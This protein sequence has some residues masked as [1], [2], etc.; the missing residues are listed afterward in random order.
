MTKQ[1][2]TTSDPK[3]IEVRP[4]VWRVKSANPK[5]FF[6]V[7]LGKKHAQANSLFLEINGKRQ[8][9]IGN[10]CDTCHFWFKCLQEPRSFAQKK[11][12]NLPKSLAVPRPLDPQLIGELSPMLEL[13]DKGDHYIFNTSLNL[14]GPYAPDDESS[15]F[16]NAEFLEIW[17]IEDPASEDILSQWEHYEGKTPRVYRHEGILEKQFDF[18]VPL[19]PTKKL[20]QANIRLYQQMIQGGDRPRILVLGLY[21][22]AVPES[23]ST[24]Q[25]KNLHSFFAGFV[26]DGHHKLAAY[27]RSGVPAHFIVVLAPKASKFSLLEGEGSNPKT[28]LEERLATLVR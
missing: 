24:S 13:M 8:F 27:T 18:I 9:E 26:L 5:G 28:R 4:G 10:D 17:D 16:H 14:T 20:K 1:E 7:G 12:V 22:R 11:V 6:H 3:P 2:S 21:Q 25:S 23:V 19:V 15:Y